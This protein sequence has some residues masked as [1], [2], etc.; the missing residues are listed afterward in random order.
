MTLDL[1][2]GSHIRTVT[3]SGTI[4]LNSVTYKVDTQRA[5]EHVLVIPDGDKVIITDL[6]GEVLAEHTRPTP[7]INYVGN[8]RP[9]GPRPKTAELSP[10]S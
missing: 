5:F 3:T 10:M 6:H 4:S 7:G 9:S 1:P 2:A 8:G